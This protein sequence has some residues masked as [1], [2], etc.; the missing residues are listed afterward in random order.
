MKPLAQKQIGSE[1]N[2][3][4]PEAGVYTEGGLVFVPD[5]DTKGH[6]DSKLNK[7]NFLNLYN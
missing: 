5:S 6:L 3:N 2:E 1:S 7:G 4:S